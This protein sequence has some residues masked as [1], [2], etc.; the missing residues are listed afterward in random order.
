MVISVKLKMQQ[1]GFMR[2]AAFCQLVFSIFAD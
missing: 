1:V 2:P